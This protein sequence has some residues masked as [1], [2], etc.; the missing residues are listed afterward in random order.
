MDDDFKDPVEES[1]RKSIEQGF[2]AVH[3][4][5][6]SEEGFIGEKSVEQIEKENA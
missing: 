2:D 1:P 5:T 4:S 3:K 6:D